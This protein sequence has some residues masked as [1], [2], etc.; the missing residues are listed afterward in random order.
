V[1][2]DCLFAAAQRDASRALAKLRD[3]LLHP[4]APAL[5]LL[6]GLDVGLENRHGLSLPLE[7][8]EGL[9]C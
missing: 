1:S 9:C 7:P 6:A 4:R 3:E 8:N 2:L 5:V